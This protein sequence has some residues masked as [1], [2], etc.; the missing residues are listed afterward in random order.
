MMTRTKTITTTKMEVTIK[1]METKD[2]TTSMEKGQDLLD[3]LING[4]RR[5]S[6][7]AQQ[8]L[9]DALIAV[10]VEQATHNCGS[11]GWVD[12]LNIDLDR[13]VLLGFVKEKDQFVHH[14]EP[15][16]DNDE[17]KLLRQLDLLQE[18]EDTDA[19][20]VL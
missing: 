17:R 19:I 3:K 4:D 20:D 9:D 16:C 13:L 10:H 15:V 14:V 5:W 12:A 7:G 6:N 11:S 8:V 1:T 2:M 18:V